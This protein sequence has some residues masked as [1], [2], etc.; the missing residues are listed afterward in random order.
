M[1]HAIRLTVL[2]A[3]QN[4]SRTIFFVID[5]YV[6]KWILLHFPIGYTKSNENICLETNSSTWFTSKIWPVGKVI[7]KRQ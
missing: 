4:W 6:V 5:K 7:G 3:I 1:V 2:A